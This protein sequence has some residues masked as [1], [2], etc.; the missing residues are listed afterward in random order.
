MSTTS[1]AIA[2]H[3]PPA[4]SQEARRKCGEEI[5]TVAVPGIRPSFAKLQKANREFQTVMDVLAKN[6]ADASQRV[7]GA[8]IARE[9]GEGEY[10]MSPI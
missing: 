10:L 2:K 4:Y 8:S 7:S 3:A 5:E 9:F 1:P 6:V